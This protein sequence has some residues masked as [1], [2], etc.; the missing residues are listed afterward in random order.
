MIGQIFE[1]WTVIEN[2]GHVMV[3]KD[4][5]TKRPTYLCRCSCGTYGVVIANNLLS[6]ISKSCGCLKKD[7]ISQKKFKHGRNQADPTYMSWASM[8]RRCNGK[9]TEKFKS[10]GARGIT[11]TS[12]WDDFSNFLEDMGERPKGMTLDR[13]DVNGNYCK[14][15]CRW[16]DAVTQANNKRKNAR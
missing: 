13:I 12:R 16:A 10:Y 2:T 14:E 15:N 11:I 6:K 3:G 5:K 7:M 1:R 8:R 4:K 9:N